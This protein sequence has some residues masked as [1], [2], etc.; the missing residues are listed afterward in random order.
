MLARCGEFQV[1]VQGISRTFRHELTS[2][3]RSRTVTL[4]LTGANLAKG[5]QG[6]T[7]AALAVVAAKGAADRLV[8]LWDG[9]MPLRR[10][11]VSLEGSSLLCVQLTGSVVQSATHYA[12]EAGWAT[13]GECTSDEA[14]ASRKWAAGLLEQASRT[15]KHVQVARSTLRQVL[16]HFASPHQH[17][18]ESPTGCLGTQP[19]QCGPTHRPG[20]FPEGLHVSAAGLRHGPQAQGVRQAARQGPPRWHVQ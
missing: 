3:E 12:V 13:R 19:G 17:R 1:Q 16:G 8:T 7:A 2:A 18:I 6:N 5:E 4:L 10:A 9:S 20:G 11:G 15:F 14:E